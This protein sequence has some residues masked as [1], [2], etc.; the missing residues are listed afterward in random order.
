MVFNDHDFIKSTVPLVVLFSV[1]YFDQTIFF[2]LR[3]KKKQDRVQNSLIS[4]DKNELVDDD[5]S[6]NNTHHLSLMSIGNKK[7]KV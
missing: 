2:S 5:S 6:N 7:K 1:G 3:H 4:M